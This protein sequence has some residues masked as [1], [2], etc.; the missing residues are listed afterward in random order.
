M[1][2]VAKKSREVIVPAFGQKLKEAR[3]ALTPGKVVA[4]IHA[5]SPLMH[6]FTRP[7]L[8]RYESGQ[9]PRPDP[10]ALAFLAE[11]YKANLG[12]WISALVAEREALLN[13]DLP[14][15]PTA[16]GESPPGRTR[17][18]RVKSARSK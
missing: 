6:G 2:A 4:K 10:A 12:D 17:P 9:T 13:V 16:S 15:S 1:F 5:M 3:G 8:D 7:Q 14:E 11:L 18:V